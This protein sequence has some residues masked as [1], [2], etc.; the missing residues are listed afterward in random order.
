MGKRGRPGG[1]WPVLY[2]RAALPS[3]PLLPLAG[4]RRARPGLSGPMA[5]AANS[6]GG[7]GAEGSAACC[8]ALEAQQ[9]PE[10]DSAAGPAA[11]G[12]AGRA[13]PGAPAPATPCAAGRA[14]AARRDAPVVRPRT[15]R[16]SKPTHALDDTEKERLLA[17]FRTE[18]HAAGTRAARGSISATW[19]FYHRRWFGAEVP[20]LPLTVD[21]LEAVCCQL[22]DRG[23]SG[24][25]SY[26]STMKDAHLEEGF[27]WTEFLDRA[28]R[29]ASRSAMRGIGGPKQDRELDLDGVHALQLG[30]VPVVEAGPVGPGRFCEFASFFVLREIEASLCLARSVTITE[31]TMEVTVA[32]P[33]C[34]TDPR[35]VGCTRTWGCACSGGHDIPCAYHALLEQKA[36]LVKAFGEERAQGDELPLFP[37]TAG[38]TVGKAR[39]VA[40]VEAI[41][42]RLGLP[43][44]DDLG[45]CCYGGHTFRITGSRRLAAMGIS[46]AVIMLLARWGSDVVHRYVAE[47]PLKCLTSEF[48]R[49]LQGRAFALDDIVQ[50]LQEKTL[51]GDQIRGFVTRLEAIEARAADYES[52]EAELAAIR[53][54]CDNI[55]AALEWPR[56]VRNV[57]TKCLHHSGGSGRMSLQSGPG[58]TP[59]GWVFTASTG[60]VLKEPPA[61]ASAR[62]TCA[63]CLPE[64]RTQLAEGQPGTETDEA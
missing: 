22:K 61:N 35:A 64:L 4:D 51:Q 19:E 43:I 55:D 21:K 37:T 42:T 1:F 52:Q 53:N 20:V 32:L 24:V 47:S 62:L 2:P 12:A 49:R 41:A 29:R 54:R 38:A 27:G 46:I 5:A 33:V 30:D 11:P 58:R 9:P 44:R 18:V 26:L 25:P 57:A 10:R 63:R 60:E 14:L 48:R 56:Y 50:Q 45:R 16:A 36:M 17:K 39:V 7:S 8:P 23:Y 31:R 34:K 40:M 13:A 15:E 3:R 6:C 28:V 59:C